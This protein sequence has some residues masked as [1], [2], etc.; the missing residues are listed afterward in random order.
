MR[1]NASRL[2]ET[3]MVS[4]TIGGRNGGLCRLALTDED[5][6]MRDLFVQWCEE[7]GCRVSID[8]LGSIFARRDGMENSLPPV[9]I[10]SHLDS[11]ETGGRFDGVL[12][13]LSGL[14][15][16]RT[17]NDTQAVTRRPL[18][19]VCWTN[20]E[21]AR[22][23]PPVLASGA[24]VGA[25]NVDDVL[26]IRD[27]D[28][29]VFGE[30]L[31]RIGYA[32]DM[33]VGERALD[34]YFELHIEQGPV[35]DEAGIDVGV[36]TG[37]YSARGFCLSLEGVTAHTG[38]TPMDRR[39]DALAAA[40]KLVAAVY[41]LG[42]EYHAT[43]GKATTTQL[44][45]SPNKQGTICDRAA[46]TCDFRHADPSVLE[47]MERTFLEAITEISRQTNVKMEITRRWSYGEEAFDVELQELVRKTARGLGVGTRDILSQAGHDAYYLSR[48]TPTALIFT[49]CKGGVSHNETED[50][51]LDRTE[52][53]VNTLLH[54]VL[55]RANR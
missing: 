14:E 5:K 39:Q 10:G 54:A 51:D 9:L 19:L 31:Q 22:F 27:A 3:L 24:F 26:G 42:W 25:N 18:E 49:P 35:L 32:G 52:P 33:A 36:V 46:M 11:Q 21:G 29:Y 28:G 15:I 20:E 17:L 41:D 2:W 40:G 23:Q 6:Q 16:I 38:P 12:G 30:E 53:G 37:G 1:I 43:D 13:V 44:S 47:S 34:A 55:A 7:A 4:A 50:I 48:V 45:C 8:R